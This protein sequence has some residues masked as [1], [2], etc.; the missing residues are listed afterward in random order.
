MVDEIDRQDGWTSK[1]L[2]LSAELVNLNSNSK[3]GY[4]PSKIAT[5]MLDDDWDSQRKIVPICT[6][7]TLLAEEGDAN[8]A[9]VSVD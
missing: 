8:A 3:V 7:E 4:V 1:E 9:G 5:Q 6:E 2:T